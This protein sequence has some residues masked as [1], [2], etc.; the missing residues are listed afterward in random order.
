MTQAPE[1]VHHPI[2]ARFWDRLSRR[3]EE[4]EQGEHRNELLRGLAGRVVEVGAGNGINFR[5]YP[6]AVT[7]V[8]AVE[9]ESHL[10]EKATDA[11]RTAPVGV[12]VVDGVAGQI[13]AEDGS[14]DAAV[15]CLVLCSVPAQDAALRE[16]RRV[17]KPGGE[18]RF[19]E[20]VIADKPAAARFMRASDRLFW[21][22]VAGGCHLGRDTAPAIE[23][24]GF[25]V[26]SCRRFPYSPVPLQP[27]LPHILGI[28]RRPA[29]DAG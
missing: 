12:R 7:E 28:A 19:Y 10:R 16:L 21:P 4:A 11:A 9:P 8:L 2:F 25:T 3:A 13:P 15:A 29:E 1:T 14:F 26:E 24:A 22:R 18:L 6:A 5:H 17:L 27:G 20:H 23:A